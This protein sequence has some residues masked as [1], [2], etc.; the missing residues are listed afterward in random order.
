MKHVEP[1]TCKCG[2]WE[3]MAAKVKFF[4]SVV[5]WFKR[6]ARHESAAQFTYFETPFQI[7]N[8][9]EATLASVQSSS[10]PVP[11][12]IKMSWLT[13]ACLPELMLSFKHHCPAPP[14]LFLTFSCVP[15]SAKSYEDATI[16][17]KPT[18]E[19]K[20]VCGCVCLLAW[21]SD[22]KEIWS[23]HGPLATAQDVSQKDFDCSVND[24]PSLH[25][26]AVWSDHYP[27]FLEQSH[28]DLSSFYGLMDKMSF[29]SCADL[30]KSFL[31][32]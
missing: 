28:C 27:S 20:R 2:S 7:D 6:H 16:S 10:T 30:M 4:F 15:V 9:A 24:F 21:R 25:T 29:L 22:N 1:K 19:V 3:N 8:G 26:L 14:A 23:W 11:S 18:G 17:G 13:R 12:E 5:H 32:F 31:Y